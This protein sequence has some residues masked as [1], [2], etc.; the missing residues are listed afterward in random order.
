MKIPSSEGIQ[1]ISGT[2]EKGSQRE[3]R[4]SRGGAR[5]L[6]G[7]IHDGVRFA[8]TQMNIERT[9]FGAVE[10]A[11][12]AAAEHRELIARFIDRAVPV[13]SFRNR[14]RGTSR[15]GSRDQFGRRSRAESREMPRIIPWRQ[16]LQNSQAILAVGH[17]SKRARRYHPDLHVVDVVELAFRRKKLIELR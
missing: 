11:G 15:A 5:V 16:N 17:E 13:N 12:P 14:E 3:R 7:I 4:W 1:P 8:R 6:D 2:R 9:H 10:R